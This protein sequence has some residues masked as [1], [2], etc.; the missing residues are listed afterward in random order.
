MH[1]DDRGDMGF[2]ESMVALIAVITVLTCYL[3]VLAGTTVV[4]TD[5][6]DG[7]EPDRFEG[8]IVNG[9]YEPDFEAYLHSFMEARDINGMTI[10]VR[11]PGDFC[12]DFH[13]TI[14]DMVGNLHS[15]VFTALVPTDDGRTLTGIYGV[16]LCV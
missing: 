14:G 11:V 3:G 5:P 7:L 12:E 2:M 15:R 1:T 16:T 4:V 6:T 9:T 13:L 10:D 8:T